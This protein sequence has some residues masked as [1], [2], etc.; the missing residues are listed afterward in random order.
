MQPEPLIAFHQA[1]RYGPGHCPPDLFDGTVPSI[2]RGLKAHANNIGHARHVALEETYPRLRRRMGSDSF[3]AA[4][5]RFL[6]DNR[7]LGRSLDTLGS[8][9]ELFLENPGERDLARAEWA[10]LEAYGAA[11]GAVLTLAELAKMDPHSLVDAHLAIHPATRCVALEAPESFVWED[12]LA[13]DGNFLLLSR[14]HS[15]VLVRRIDAVEAKIVAL[16]ARAVRASELLGGEATALIALV[17]A[18]TIRLEDR[19]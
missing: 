3:H 5:E 18:G 9:F 15:D 7:V 8:G 13:G 2:V 17:Q 12:G 19:P 6:D 16:L 10:W 1:L 4:A 14:P 11:E